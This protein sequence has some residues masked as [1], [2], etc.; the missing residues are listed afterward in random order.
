MNGQT[1]GGEAYEAA[2]EDSP[3]YE[4]FYDEAPM[5]ISTSAPPSPP[6]PDPSTFVAPDH[7]VLFCIDEPRIPFQELDIEA[8][9]KH[10]RESVATA[11]NSIGRSYYLLA[12]S[13]ND[14][15]LLNAS[16]ECFERASKLAGFTTEE[17]GAEGGGGEG[18]GVA[19]R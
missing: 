15:A 3:T 13:A 16:I 10:S 17:K 5:Q 6:P 1:K 12:Y 7:E 4:E 19:R 9:A 2:Y 18:G 8:A 11:L 14:E